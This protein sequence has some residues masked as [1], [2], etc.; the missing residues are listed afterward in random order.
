MH[1]CCCPA[2]GPSPLYVILTVGLHGISGSLVCLAS[3]IYA[4]DAQCSD[5]MTTFGPLQLLW[6]SFFIAYAVHLYR[7]F[8]VPY[9]TRMER[10]RSSWQRGGAA[11]TA[12]SRRHYEG[13]EADGPCE[14]LLYV[15]LYDP[16][17]LA[18]FLFC[19]VQICWIVFGYRWVDKAVNVDCPSFMTGTVRAACVCAIL[20]L[21]LG[22]SI[23]MI[24]T[25]FDSCTHEDRRIE[26]AYSNRGRR[27]DGSVRGHGASR[28]QTSRA[29]ESANPF[30]V[31]AGL[32]F[33]DDRRSNGS[34][35]SVPR[36]EAHRHD[37]RMATGFPATMPPTTVPPPVTSIAPAGTTSVEYQRQQLEYYKQQQMQREAEQRAQLGL[38]RGGPSFGAGDTRTEPSRRPAAPS[39]PMVPPS[40]SSMSQPSTTSVDDTSR[41]SSSATSTKEKASQAAKKGAKMIGKG[42]ASALRAAGDLIDKR[43]ESHEDQTGGAGGEGPTGVAGEFP[44]PPTRTTE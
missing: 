10:F 43:S 40:T 36:N 30:A 24:T 3:F 37:E 11:E 26:E 1:R 12:S 2:D 27:D 18:F 7:V 21:I 15:F 29:A 23:I 13:Q 28:G 34:D 38:D 33:G 32:L 20:H 42:V 35:R 9:A 31:V 6:S 8:A 5:E 22:T 19:V 39:Q 14:R 16:W 25:M 4:S 41:P 44:K 17:T